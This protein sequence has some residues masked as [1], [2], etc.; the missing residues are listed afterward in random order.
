MDATKFDKEARKLAESFLSARQ[1]T[2]Q[3]VVKQ[4]LALQA[5]KASGNEGSEAYNKIQKMK[6][7]R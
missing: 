4:K 6:F 3:L 5:L 1:E 2:E 7:P